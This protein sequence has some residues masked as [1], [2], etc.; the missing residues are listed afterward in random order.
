MGR[1]TTEIND[2]KYVI[3]KA[4]RS[5]AGDCVTTFD[6]YTGPTCES[7]F[8]KPGRVYSSFPA[9]QKDADKLSRYNPVGFIVAGIGWRERG[10]RWIK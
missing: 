10:G 5:H 1:N 8:V 2:M 4:S 3:I 7:A 9:A 6:A